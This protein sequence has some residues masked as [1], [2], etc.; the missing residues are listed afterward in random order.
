MQY[1]V[2]FLDRSD[3]VVRELQADARSAGFPLLTAPPAHVAQVRVIY[4]SGYVS[5]V[6]LP[7][8]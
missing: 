2:Q 6:R 3:K 7:G 8:A 5:T 1:R 4:P